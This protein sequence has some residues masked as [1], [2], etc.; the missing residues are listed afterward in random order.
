M[1]AACP[2]TGYWQMKLRAHKSALQT[3]IKKAKKDNYNSAMGNLSL[4][5]SILNTKKTECLN[6]TLSSRN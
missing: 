2:Q 6:C 1:G 5:T 4:K 3:G